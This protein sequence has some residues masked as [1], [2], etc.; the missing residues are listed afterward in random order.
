MI[1][2][3]QSLYLLCAAILMIVMLFMP[4]ATLTVGAGEKESIRTEA[5]GSIVKTT[6]VADSNVELNVWGIYTDEKQDVPLVFLSILACLTA[7][8]S[9]VNI[10]LYRRRGLQ[11]RLCFVTGIM[12]IGIL[13]FIGLYIYQLN[14]VAATQEFTA[15]R[16]SVADLF[17][18]LAMLFVWLA[19]RG[20]VSDIALVRSLDRIR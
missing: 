11:L 12:L 13:A 10:F 1:Q 17:P 3:K 19:Y 15:I 5:D 8:V 9:F 14:G 16:Y 20:I 4:I 6:I 2:R 18:L 7:V